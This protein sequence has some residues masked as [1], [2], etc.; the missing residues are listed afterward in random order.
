[1]RSIVYNCSLNIPIFYAS[2]VNYFLIFQY[3]VFRQT[4]A[5][6]LCINPETVEFKMLLAFFLT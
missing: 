3:L 6:T 2:I 1:M 5:S 4:R